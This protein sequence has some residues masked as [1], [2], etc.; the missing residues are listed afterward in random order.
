M[1]PSA[2]G[3]WGASESGDSVVVVDAES[4]PAVQA[5]RVAAKPNPANPTIS[6]LEI[7]FLLIIVTLLTKSKS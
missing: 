5:P 4:V 1:V 3:L 7:E 6:L 2:I